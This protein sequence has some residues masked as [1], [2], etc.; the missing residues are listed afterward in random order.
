MRWENK[1]E[2]KRFQK[3]FNE[4]YTEWN[5]V[6]DSKEEIRLRLKLQSMNDMVKI[7]RVNNKSVKRIVKED[8]DE[9]KEAT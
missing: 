3:L 5:E 6:E 9:N 8:K 1:E 2:G 7:I 4:I